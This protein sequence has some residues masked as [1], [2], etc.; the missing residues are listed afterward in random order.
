MNTMEKKAESARWAMEKKTEAARWAKIRSALAAR[1]LDEGTLDRNMMR[2][3]FW[4]GWTKKQAQQ[5][6][7]LSK[8]IQGE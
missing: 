6:I 1:G 3:L 4:D 5:I 2:C 7:E 8:Q